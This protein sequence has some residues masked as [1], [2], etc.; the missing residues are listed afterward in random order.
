MPAI[1]W[2]TAGLMCVIKH[3]ES[4]E[5]VKALADLRL[6][7]ILDSEEHHMGLVCH[8][9]LRELLEARRRRRLNWVLVA[10]AVLPALAGAFSSAQGGS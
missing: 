5:I 2:R 4:D 7:F 1:P 6:V 3:K 8:H 9:D 10:A